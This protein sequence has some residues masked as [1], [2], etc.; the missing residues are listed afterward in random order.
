MRPS[1]L[2]PRGV[3]LALALA[4][5]AATPANAQQTAFSDSLLDRMVGHWVL[6]GTIAGQQ[7]THDVVAEWVLGHEYIRLQEVSRERA[8]GGG[9]AYEAMVLI[10]TDPEHKGGLAC[11]WLDN[12]GAGGLLGRALGHAE[13]STGDRIPFLFKGGDG[14]VFHTTFVYDRKADRWQ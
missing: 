14:S 7:T 2:S 13:T 8:P 9:P 6:S 3:G 10:G 1:R 4:A 5:V 12:T 11:L